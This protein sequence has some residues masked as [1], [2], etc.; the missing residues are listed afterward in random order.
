MDH[1]SLGKLQQLIAVARCG[2]FSKAA[3]ELNISQPALSRS[4][5]AV[6]E[7][8]GFR[9]FNRVGHGVHLTAAGIQV[10]EQ[11]QPVLQGLRTFDNNL[12]LLGSGKAGQLS[13]GFAPLLASEVLSQ[14]ACEFFASDS[15]V[16]LRVQ[17]RPGPILLEELQ[18]DAIEMFFCP[19]SQIEP[20]PEIDTEPLG[21]IMPIC[22]VRRAHPLASRR[23]L[24]LKDLAGFPWA[25]SVDP[26]IDTATP[27]QIAGGFICDNFHVLRE[28][29]LG[30]NLIY[31]CSPAFVAQELATGTLIQIRVVDL[32]LRSTRI[33]MVKLRDRINSPLAEQA[34]N[35]MRVRLSQRP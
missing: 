2:S 3:T 14:F 18:N 27:R 6:E 8:Y 19:D 22:V 20:N 5:A 10:L 16:H 29:V 11:A 13:L 17:V 30:T 23:E 1:L 21:A 35:R 25:S 28:A 34:L 24:K 26:P 32:K 15:H 33:M 7:R 31:I 12:R 4:I 9:I